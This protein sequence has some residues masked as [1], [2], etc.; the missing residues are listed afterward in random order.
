MESDAP[1]AKPLADRAYDLLTLFLGV[2]IRPGEAGGMAANME[3][4]GR[5]AVR[6][7][8][9]LEAEVE[10][11]TPRPEPEKKRPK[12]QRP[13]PPQPEEIDLDQEPGFYDE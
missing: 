2:G 10:A 1:P 6:V 13:A 7:C 4:L 3:E 11:A 12:P 8:R 9:A 5:E